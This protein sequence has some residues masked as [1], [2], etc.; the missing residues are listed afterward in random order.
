M[1]ERLGL[2]SLQFLHRYKAGRALSLSTPST[3]LLGLLK[4]YRR[5]TVVATSANAALYSIVLPCGSVACGSIPSRQ[6]GKEGSRANRAR[7]YRSSAGFLRRLSFEASI[8][9]GA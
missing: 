4:R 6:I 9:K 2:V 3:S 8:N 1:F 5:L 7:R